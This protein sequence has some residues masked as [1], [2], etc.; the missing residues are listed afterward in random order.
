[1]TAELT[2]TEDE[3]GLLGSTSPAVLPS[4]FLYFRHP[5]DNDVDEGESDHEMLQIVSKQAHLID[6]LMQT[7]VQLNQC[8]FSAGSSQSQSTE[9]VLPQQVF[10]S[11]VG[12]SCVFPFDWKKEEAFLRWKEDNDE[13]LTMQLERLRLRRASDFDD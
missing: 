7:C 1:M 8:G 5:D 9:G 10:G 11:G 12:A 2:D 4:L 3:P 13:C 6:A